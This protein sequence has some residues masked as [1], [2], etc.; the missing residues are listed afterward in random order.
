LYVLDERLIYDSYVNYHNELDSAKEPESRAELIQWFKQRG[1]ASHQRLADRCREARV[2]L[3]WEL[4][5]GGVPEMVL[6]AA[7]QSQLVVVGRRGFGHAAVPAYLGRNLR[8]IARHAPVPVLVGSDR[9]REIHSLLLVYSQSRQ[10]SCA[11]A[12]ARSLHQML[13][14]KIYVLA[15]ERKGLMPDAQTKMLERLAEGDPNPYRFLHSPG[16]KAA[17]IVAAAQANA[18]DLVVMDGSLSA[19]QLSWPLRHVADEV[20]KATDLP[21]LIC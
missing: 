18:V 5:L 21:L 13:H 20:L 10:V 19:W 7:A 8:A 15:F 16:D 6:Q 12:W 3:T 1:E 2:P 4:L 9:Y 11:L 17:A 14:A